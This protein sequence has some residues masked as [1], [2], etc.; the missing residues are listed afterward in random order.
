MLRSMGMDR[1]LALGRWF[2]P[3]FR[4]LKHARRL[5]GTPLDVFGYA[6]VRRVERTLPGEYTELVMRA[7]D[8]ARTD[9]LST[10]VAVAELP[11]VV[12]GYEQ[13][14]L[15]NVERFRS[16]ATRLLDE[17]GQNGH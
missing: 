10:V 6:R 13:I 8:G 2:V 5:R 15:D 7:L 17:L 14:K 3:V 16:E 12:R 9:T 11:D 4:M 1:K